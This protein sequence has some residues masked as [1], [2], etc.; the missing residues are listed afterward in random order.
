MN[1]IV[2]S[3]KTS[4]DIEYAIGDEIE[5]LKLQIGTMLVTLADH[6]DAYM[7]QSFILIDYLGREVRSEA[8]LIYLSSLSFGAGGNA[9]VSRYVVPPSVA[10]NT[11]TWYTG[12]AAGQTAESSPTADTPAI[13]LWIVYKDCGVS[14]ISDPRCSREVLLGSVSE[15]LQPCFR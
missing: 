12:T 6:G 13:T 2:W 8:D 3:E 9:N 5:V 14:R 4:V 7:D 15:L 10:V 11:Y 1:L